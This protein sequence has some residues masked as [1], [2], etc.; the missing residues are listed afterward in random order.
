MKFNFKHQVHVVANFPNVGCS[1][2]FFFHSHKGSDAVIGRQPSSE[3]RFRHPGSFH[4]MAL[5]SLGHEVRQWG[6]E[7]W[8]RHIC[9]TSLGQKQDTLFLLTLH[10][11]PWMARELEL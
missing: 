8:M 1:Q 6:K 10:W 7:R 5:L 11:P 3:W 4:L 2:S 9:L